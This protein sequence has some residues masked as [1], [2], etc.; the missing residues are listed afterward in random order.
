MYYIVYPIFYILSLIPFWLMYL[1]S[2]LL[3]IIIYRVWGYRTQVVSHQLQN[4]F[5]EKSDAEIHL[6]V[7]QYYRNMCDQ[8]VETIKLASISEKEIEKRF[9]I[10]YK[11]WFPYFIE[12]EKVAFWTAHFFNFE[13][14]NLTFQYQVKNY[15]TLHTLQPMDYYGVYASLG[16]KVADRVFKKLRQKDGSHLVNTKEFLKIVSKGEKINAVGLIADQSPLH[17]KSSFWID[18]F[19]QN[20]AFYSL[21][22]RLAKDRDMTVIFPQ[23]VKKKRGYYTCEFTILTDNPNEY[24]KGKLTQKYVQ[25]LEKEIRSQTPL[26]MWSH[27][28]WKR[29]YDKKYVANRIT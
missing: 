21:P 9:E 15:N 20:T 26:W 28:R 23:I 14:L 8:I 12:Q 1:L 16:N 29:S 22:E 13:W 3:Y 25:Q 7:K 27:R 19:A 5:P 11:T 6:I 24:S 17:L 2:D 4:C 10:D 18:F